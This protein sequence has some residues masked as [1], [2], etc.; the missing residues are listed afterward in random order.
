MSSLEISA[1]GT[2]MIWAIS[3]RLR[4]VAVFSVMMMA[5]ELAMGVMAP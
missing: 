3:W 1:G 4:M 5:E 2:S